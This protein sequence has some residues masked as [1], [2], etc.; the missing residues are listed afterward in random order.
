ML[1][2]PARMVESDHKEGATESMTPEEVLQFAKERGARMLDFSLSIYQ[3]L[4][5]ILV[6]LSA[7]LKKTFLS[8]EYLSTAP[9]YVDFRPLTKAIC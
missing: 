2:F 4:G 8:R 1:N 7:N 6:Y 3:A 9:A 5:S